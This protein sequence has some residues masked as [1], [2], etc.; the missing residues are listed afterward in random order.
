M[1]FVSN[2]Y[3][4]AGVRVVQC[5]VRDIRAQRLAEEQVRKLSRAVE[6]S[7][8]AIVISNLAGEI[9]YVNAAL[10]HSGGYR[11]EELIGKPALMLQ[12]TGTRPG[13]MAELAAAL[14]EGKVWRG[15]FS[16]HHKDGSAF[17]DFAIVAPIHR[18]DGSTSNFLTI[19]EDITVRE[20]DAAEL[21]RHRHA[22]EAL[23]DSR[24]PD[25]W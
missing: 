8:V 25:G 2:A 15:E 24:T 7:P 16:G 6:Q 22:L 9:E 23:V 10:L 1:E 4:C 20:R 17:I 11:A 18:L 3:D 12:S 21:D 19:T 13:T 14:A 5:N